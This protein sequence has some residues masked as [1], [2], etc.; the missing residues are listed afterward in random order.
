[1]VALPFAGL[2]Y[3]LFKHVGLSE[4][5][6]TAAGIVVVFIWLCAAIALITK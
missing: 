5:I 4:A 1:M 2:F 3:M 6:I